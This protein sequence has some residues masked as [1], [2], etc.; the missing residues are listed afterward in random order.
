MGGRRLSQAT[1]NLGETSL[2]SE[3][4][5]SRATE[6]PGVTLSSKGAEVQKYRVRGEVTPPPAG[7]SD[8]RVP[9]AGVSQQALAQR[10]PPGPQNIPFKG[11]PGWVQ[12]LQD[13]R[14]KAGL[15]GLLRWVLN[16]GIHPRQEHAAGLGPAITPHCRH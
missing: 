4:P 12:V 14:C 7:V 15:T 2:P 9:P 6:Q 16:V 3:S 10:S 8:S 1:G 11:W 5:S 13:H